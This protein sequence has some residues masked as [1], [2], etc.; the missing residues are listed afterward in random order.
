MKRIPLN[1]EKWYKTK[2]ELEA[3]YGRMS[4]EEVQD[5]ILEIIR[6]HRK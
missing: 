5:K 4:N 1:P 2:G 3:E 6:E